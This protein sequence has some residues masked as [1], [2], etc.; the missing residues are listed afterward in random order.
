MLKD[1]ASKNGVLCVKLLTFTRPGAQ[2]SKAI[3]LCLPAV[4]KTRPYLFFMR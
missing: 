3:A 1:Q 2:G 4:G